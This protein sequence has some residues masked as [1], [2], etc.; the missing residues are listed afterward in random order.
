MF[1]NRICLFNDSCEHSYPHGGIEPSFLLLG[2]KL[3][4]QS[5]TF[6][7]KRGEARIRVAQKKLVCTREEKEKGWIPA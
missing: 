2:C 4:V 5:A 1:K 3:S 6:L 7:R